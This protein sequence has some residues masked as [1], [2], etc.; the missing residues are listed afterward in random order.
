VSDSSTDPLETLQA[1]LSY[2]FRDRRLLETAVTHPSYLQEHPGIGESNQ[3]LEFLGD[4]V[5]QLV[6]TE[7]LYQLFPHEREGALSK[8]RSTVTKGQF[9]TQLARSFGLDQALRLAAAEAQNGGSTRA[10]TL[11]DAFEAVIGAIY[12]DSDFATA[13]RTILGLYGDLPSRLASHQEAENPK[14]QLQEL[15]QPAH[16]NN[17]LR[18]AVTHISGED[19]AR[20]YEAQVFLKD[21]LLGTGRGTSKKSAEEAAA[22]IALTRVKE[23][24]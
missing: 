18:Y 7:T 23:I 16:G 6:I 21:Q 3:R 4:A 19:H 24:S 5:L 2:R 15:I 20:E 9:L 14:G 17:A 12:L 13:R 1:R 8:R 11:E 22:R 10:S